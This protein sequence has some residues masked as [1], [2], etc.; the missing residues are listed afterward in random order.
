M[1]NPNEPKN[2]RVG[3]TTIVTIAD[4]DFK[5]KKQSGYSFMQ[6]YGTTRRPLADLYKDLIMISVEGINEQEVME[7][8]TFY[9]MPLALQIINIHEQ[10]IADF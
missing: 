3:E 5:V 9:F 1:K 6:V 10:Q 4:R 2:L 8:D 7:L